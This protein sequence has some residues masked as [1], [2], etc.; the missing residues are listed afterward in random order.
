[1]LLI[2]LQGFEWCRIGLGFSRKGFSMKKTFL[3]FFVLCGLV[4][5]GLQ[6]A[7]VGSDI[8]ASIGFGD[9]RQGALVNGLIR[10]YPQMEIYFNS[11]NGRFEPLLKKY[12]RAAAPLT[13]DLD[14]SQGMVRS[15]SIVDLKKAVLNAVSDCAKPALRSSKVGISQEEL[16]TLLKQ[17]SVATLRIGTRGRTDAA[18]E[19]PGATLGSYLS[20]TAWREWMAS[21]VKDTD[22][23]ELRRGS[24]V[25]AEL[26]YVAPKRGWGFSIPKLGLPS[27]RRDAEEPVAAAA[28]GSET[29]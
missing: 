3:M 9:S 23:V 27:W 29:H 5:V 21:G 20:P 4:A 16:T 17:F 26:V 14:S 1:M 12:I 7:E 6:A 10:S 18:E 8:R 25:F 24:L 19:A 13:E 28:P 2:V 15:I 11:D 22:V